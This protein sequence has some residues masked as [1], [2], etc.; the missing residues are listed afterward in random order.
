[1]R[2]RVPILLVG[3][4]LLAR[5]PAGE[6]DPAPKPAEAAGIQGEPLPDEVKARL[7]RKVTA[8][9]SDSPIEDGVGFLRSLSNLP[10]VLDPAL[11]KDAKNIT[12]KIQ[13]Q[14]MG[15]TLVSIAGMAGGK[16]WYVDGMF[17]FSKHEACSDV[18]VKPLPVPAISDEQKAKVEA[19]LKDFANDDYDTRAAA[20]KSVQAVGPGAIS[21]LAKAV[22]NE[23]D[24]A[25]RLSQIEALLKEF[26]GILNRGELGEAAMKDL[27]RKITFEFV[28]T[29]LDEGLA[30]L[31]S[32]TKVK[33][34]LLVSKDAARIPVSLRVQD[35]ELA[36]ALRWIARL[37][38]TKLTYHADQVTFVKESK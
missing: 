11:L 37:A 26:N 17:W 9:L 20:K 10:I 18:K 14:K 13:E 25:E 8:D 1:M 32:L 23:G 27:N 19:A 21:I 6:A 5:T 16:I 31:S 33:L 15:D 34:N 22:E 38:E 7:E 2:V 29:P 30:F 3:C 4:L 24:D 36:R 28:D 35:M 12:L